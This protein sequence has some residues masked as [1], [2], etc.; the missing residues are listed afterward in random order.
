M[1][2]REGDFAWA[3]IGFH[4]DLFL[5]RLINTKNPPEF[6]CGCSLPGGITAGDERFLEKRYAEGMAPL[7]SEARMGYVWSKAEG[8]VVEAG[9]IGI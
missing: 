9:K 4:E 1:G 6:R 8:R 5:R 2:K 7:G 3:A